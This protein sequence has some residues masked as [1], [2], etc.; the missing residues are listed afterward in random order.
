VQAPS[1]AAAG[2]PA[3]TGAG[4]AARPPAGAAPRGRSR[5]GAPAA[6]A[7][8]A[9]PPPPA[10]AAALPLPDAV[11]TALVAAAPK[12]AGDAGFWSGV[13][14]S[15]AGDSFLALQFYLPSDKQT[16]SPACR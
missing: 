10:P 8:A 11:K 2:A 4:T 13:F 7:A 9:P 3:G 16:L 5:P 6:G 15:N 14:R 1:A 12:G